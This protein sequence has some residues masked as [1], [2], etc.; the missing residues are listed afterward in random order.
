VLAEEY[1][2]EI[3]GPGICVVLVGNSPRDFE[4]KR[5]VLEQI[6]ADTEAT[7]LKA[8]EEGEVHDGFVWCFIR[9]TA[10]IR[11]TMRATGVFG[12]EVFGTDSY[13]VLRNAVQHSRADK[14]T[15]IDL[16]L[17]F[18]DNVDPFITSLEQGQL[19]HSEVLLRW[20]PAPDVA[21]GA[22][23]YVGKANAQTVDGHHGLPHHLFSDSMHDFFGPHS[24]NYTHW[25]RS[26][27]KAFDPN[28]VSESSN[29]ISAK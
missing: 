22:M 8:V 19:T 29:H 12:G 2:K 15:L 14:K 27:K 11:E 20:A 9:V 26:I 1:A 4:Y 5:A 25:L 23:D 7:S 3:V 24:T 18:P 17:V 6:I 21:A 13:R 10:S 16:G 28:G